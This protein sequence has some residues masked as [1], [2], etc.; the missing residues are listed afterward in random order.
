MEPGF[1][2]LV[3]AGTT[4]FHVH[5]VKWEDIV[6]QR[7]VKRGKKAMS[8]DSNYIWMRHRRRQFID[9][10]GFIVDNSFVLFL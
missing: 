6:W 9:I 3:Q 1:D 2:V 8:E 4:E 7:P 10:P 5:V